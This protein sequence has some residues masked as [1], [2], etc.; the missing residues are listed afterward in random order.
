MAATKNTLAEGRQFPKRQVDQKK[1]RPG[2]LPGHYRLIVFER[3][4]VAITATTPTPASAAVAT[5]ATTAAAFTGSHRPCF[6]HH[7]RP[8]QQLPAIA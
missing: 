7:Q 2:T 1:G 4:A 3:L 8:A 5:S 6:I